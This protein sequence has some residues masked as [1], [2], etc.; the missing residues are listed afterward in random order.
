MSHRLI[1]CITPRTFTTSMQKSDCVIVECML[2]SNQNCSWVHY[3]SILTIKHFWRQ[4]GASTSLPDVL[5]LKC[6]DLE[7]RDDHPGLHQRRLLRVACDHHDPLPLL[8]ESEIS[9]GWR[10]LKQLDCLQHRTGLGQ[11][12]PSSGKT[13]SGQIWFVQ[14]SVGQMNICKRTFKLVSIGDRW[15]C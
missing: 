11:H 1:L 2:K 15:L 10:Y 7:S 4:C 9:R 3:D 5:G 8:S 6:S 12:E 14:V 13:Y